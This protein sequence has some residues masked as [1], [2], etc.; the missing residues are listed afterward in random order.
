MSTIKRTQVY[1]YEEEYEA[2]HQE[3]YKKH[4]ISSVLRGIV[5]EHLLKKVKD[6]LVGI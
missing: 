6:K 2:L 1:L 4:S 3:A 5:R